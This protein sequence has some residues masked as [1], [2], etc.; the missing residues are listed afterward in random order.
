MT[1]HSGSIEAKGKAEAPDRDASWAPLATLRHEID[2]LF[3]DFGTGLWRM[4]RARGFDPGAILAGGLRHAPLVE[5]VDCDG[6]YHVKAEVPGLSPEDIE[7][8]IEDGM[9]ILRGET[10]EE[11]RDEKGD[12][13]LSERHYGAFHRRLRLPAAADTDKVT[14]KLAQ[15]V[16]TIT[17][18]KTAHARDTARKVAITAG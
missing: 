8:R 1:Q 2:R 3:D 9:L 6:E 4:P 12:Y 16:L 10:S 7:V 18:P 13:L 11:T 5:M 15:G 14:A 17:I